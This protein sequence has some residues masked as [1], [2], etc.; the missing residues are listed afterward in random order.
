MAQ[1]T[2][3]LELL[4]SSVFINERDDKNWLRSHDLKLK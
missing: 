3:E 2:G 1:T 4:T